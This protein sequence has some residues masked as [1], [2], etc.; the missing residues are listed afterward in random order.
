VKDSG[1]AR[2][3]S[4]PVSSVSAVI[5]TYDRRDLLEGLLAS[6]E[7]Q[8]RPFDR[9]IVVDN[10]STDGSVESARRRG[11]EVIELGR[12]TGFAAAVN[13]GIEQADTEYVAVMNNDVELEA[14]WLETAGEA[15]VREG[16]W[17]AVGKVLRYDE[18]NVIDGTFDAVARSG[19]SW[20]CGHGR[21]DGPVW[22]EPRE[23]C[24]PPL[25]AAVFRRELFRRV[26]LLDERFESYLEDVD[27]GLRCAAAGLKGRYVPE[28][29]AWHRGSATLGAWGKPKVRRIARNQVWIAAK[30]LPRRWARFAWPVLVG[31]LLWGA[32]AI[33]HGAG[34]AYCRG[35][36]EGLRGWR[37]MRGSVKGAADEV[38]LEGERLIRDLQRATGSDWYWKCYF[39]LT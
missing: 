33:R 12:N 21:P 7:R 11:A 2:L 14:R 35:K 9:I 28:A 29:V 4:P 23:I 17:F 31:Q 24:L 34:L 27:L 20:R 16:G 19:C 3:P 1:V 8:T 36:L 37:A 15:L 13:R 32:V 18:R 6:L 26:G 38:F 22:N 30:H 25:T 10:G 39:A 5:P